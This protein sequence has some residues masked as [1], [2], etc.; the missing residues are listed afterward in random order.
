[1]KY[2]FLIRIAGAVLAIATAA[3][4]DTVGSVNMNFVQ[5]RNADN[6]ADSTGY[7]QVGYNYRISVHEVS[8]VQYQ[9]SGVSGG[10]DW[11]GV[12]SDDAPAA[13]MTWHQAAAYCNWM[14]ST[15]GNS[16]LPYEFNGSGEVIDVMSREEMIAHGGLFYVLPT[17]NEWYKAAYYTGS[18]YTDYANG[19]DTAPSVDD[20][21][22][23][24]SSAGFDLS[25]NAWVVDDG[26]FEQNGTKNMSGNVFEWLETSVDGGLGSSD[27]MVLRGGAAQYPGGSEESWNDR[28]H[29]EYRVDGDGNTTLTRSQSDASVGMRIVAIPEPGTMGLMGA[30]AIGLF[31]ARK[32]RRR[33]LFG[34]SVVPVRRKCRIDFFGLSVDSDAPEPAAPHTVPVVRQLLLKAGRS[35]SARV[36]DVNISFWNYMVARHERKTASRTAMKKAFREKLR[37]AFDAFLAAIMK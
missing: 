17:E 30:S 20:A 31:F 11:S 36:E 8:I 28:L 29:R 7:G 2:G 4:A 12:D 22:Y 25:R 16:S 9:A 14:T 34:E 1:M 35:V 33:R 3:G 21:N 15:A 5:I 26:S 18:G 37:N 19:T 24:D 27:E 32:L 13:N 23:Y 10:D 6:D